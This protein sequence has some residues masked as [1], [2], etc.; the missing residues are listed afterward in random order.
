MG[1]GEG[2]MRR[3][4]K[5]ARWRGQ[6]SGRAKKKKNFRYSIDTTPVRFQKEKRCNFSN[7]LKFLFLFLYFILLLVF[8]LAV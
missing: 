1:E 8:L 2:E 7:E 3:G 4:G 6:E 5:G